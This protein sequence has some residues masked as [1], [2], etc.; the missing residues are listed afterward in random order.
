MLDRQVIDS[1]FPA[2]LPTPEQLEQQYPP[3]QLPEGA[4]VTRLGPSPT[5]SVH[6]GGLYVGMINKDLAGRTGRRYLLR[7][8]DTDQAREVEGAAE[9]FTQA[10]AYFG[11]EPDESSL[12]GGDYGPYFQSQR[13][14]LYL[15][16][17]REMLREGKAY[18]CF[19]TQEELA[20]IRARQEASKAPTGY[21]GRWAI[22][23][24]A[25]DEDVQK[26]LDEGR[27]YVVRFRTPEDGE[28]R[29]SFEDAI[30]G[31]L[32]HEANRNDAVILKSS[33]TSPRL[34]TY[35]FAH[36]VDDH[37]MRVTHV[38]R[39]EEWISS[40]PLHLQ[41]FDALG[42]ERVQYAH[43]ATLM[44]QDGSSRRKLS[45]RRDPEAAVTF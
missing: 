1:L 16:F 45:K 6:I 43:V 7:V 35:H 44:K 23:R 8:E 13:E 29:V 2:D 28:R 14:T 25:A 27:P 18:L 38:I 31:K 12:A 5:G 33:A 15:T 34:P 41:L 9:Q 26:A 3:R 30:R 19:A 39:G 21:Y 10:L 20:D 11:V 24:N 36:A 22:W 37:L 17:V 42:F 32:Q 40:V 4:M